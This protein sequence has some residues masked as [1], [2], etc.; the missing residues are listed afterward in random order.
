MVL[1]IFGVGMFGST[2]LLPLYLQNALGYTAFQTG[3]VFLPVGLLQGIMAPLS[4]IMSDKSNPKVPLF[5]GIA[6]LA[7]SMYLNSFLSLYSEHFQIML[8]LYIRGFAM[9]LVF[10]PLSTIAL[11]EIHRQKIAQATGLFNV[12]R[13][14]GGS[15]GVAVFGT[16][17]I[18]R[19]IFH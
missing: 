11:S 18:R 17:L 2:F 15:F 3:L 12:I 13:Q 14:I 10:T 5:I 9:G 6:L 1:F 16:L 19:E 4:G 7:F 8:P